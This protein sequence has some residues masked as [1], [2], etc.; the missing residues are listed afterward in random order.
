VLGER[1]RNKY[2][3]FMKSHLNRDGLKTLLVDLDETL[4][5]S[6]FTQVDDSDFILSVSFY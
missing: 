6:S 5:H 4:V 2:S 1:P 3:Q